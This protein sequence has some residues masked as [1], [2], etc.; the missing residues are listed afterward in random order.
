MFWQTKKAIQGINS[1]SVQGTLTKLKRDRQRSLDS[2][3]CF[4]EKKT[5]GRVSEET[6]RVISRV[7][8]VRKLKYFPQGILIPSGTP[9]EIMAGALGKK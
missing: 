4:S 1:G 9:K 2:A 3:L 8:F 6:A 7:F 5:S